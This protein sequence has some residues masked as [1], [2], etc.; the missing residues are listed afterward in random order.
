MGIMGGRTTYRED[1]SCPHTHGAAFDDNMRCNSSKCDPLCV[2]PF[3]SLTPSTKH[4]L[5]S[6]ERIKN[7]QRTCHWLLNV[8]TVPDRERLMNFRFSTSALLRSTTANDYYYTYYTHS[9]S[10]A[11]SKMSRDPLYIATLYGYIQWHY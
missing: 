1:F 7:T 9:S 3:P 10:S 4:L 2:P 6:I 5:L 11:L 8:L